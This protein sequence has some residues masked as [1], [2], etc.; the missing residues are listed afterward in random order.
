M[1]KLTMPWD[2]SYLDGFISDVKKF[3]LCFNHQKQEKPAACTGAGIRDST[4]KLFT[5]PDRASK[6]R[7]YCMSVLRTKMKLREAEMVLDLE[8]LDVLM[9]N[10]VV[11][12]LHLAGAPQLGHEVPPEVIAQ[13]TSPEIQ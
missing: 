9:G 11:A 10:V 6:F 5:S 12:V 1:L 2:C 7:E 4:G 13:L 3:D 8:Y